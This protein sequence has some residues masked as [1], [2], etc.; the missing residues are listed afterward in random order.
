[1]RLKRFLIKVMKLQGKSHKAR[2]VQLL[3]QLALADI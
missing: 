2:E 3:Q 1:M